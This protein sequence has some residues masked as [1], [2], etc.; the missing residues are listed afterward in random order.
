MARN[1]RM[2]SSETPKIEPNRTGKKRRQEKKEKVNKMI[3]NG[4][5][6]Y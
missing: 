4:V 2:N 1:Q 3:V 5:L 6:L